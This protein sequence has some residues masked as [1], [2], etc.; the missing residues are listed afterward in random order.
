M[1]G[2]A[3]VYLFDD[4]INEVLEKMKETPGACADIS[5]NNI[6]NAYF[7]LQSALIDVYEILDTSAAGFSGKEMLKYVIKE[8][9]LRSEIELYK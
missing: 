6:I 2:G 7:V 1:F 5:V 3:V 8:R 4:N 9:A